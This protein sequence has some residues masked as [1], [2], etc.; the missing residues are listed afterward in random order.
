M[1]RD[2]D[3]IRK[4]LFYVEDKFQAGKGPIAIK[5]DNYSDEIIYEHIKLAYQ[6]GLIQKIIDAV[7][8]TSCNILVGNLTNE[9]YD[10]LDKIRDDTVW[11]KTKQT[12]KE[13]GLPMVIETIKTISTAIIAAATEGVTKAMLNNGGIQ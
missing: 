7:T 10:L 13:K 6:T 5:I 4:I 9:G 11:N 8:Y 1:K 2:M 3:L 12:I